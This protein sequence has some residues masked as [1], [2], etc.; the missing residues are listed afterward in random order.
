MRAIYNRLVDEDTLA[1]RDHAIRLH[2]FARW[3]IAYVG[4]DC[5]YDHHGYCQAHGLDLKPCPVEDILHLLTAIESIEGY[6]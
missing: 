1:L 5:R 4:E 6:E 2:G 3:A